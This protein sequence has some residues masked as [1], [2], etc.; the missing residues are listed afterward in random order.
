MAKD[1]LKV[2]TATTTA[3]EQAEAEP[4]ANREKLEKLKQ[5]R[6][7]E[8]NQT[9]AQCDEEEKKI[10]STRKALDAELTALT[11]KSSKR[12]TTGRRG[13]RPKNS[14]PLVDVIV[15][16][17]K[18]KKKGM[19]VKDLCAAVIAAGYNTSSDNFSPMVSQALKK[20]PFK[21]LSRGIYAVEK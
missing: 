2:A 5:A 19:S 14:K 18:G 6:I 21:K 12:R 20:G 7:Q 16:V 4:Q 15:S 1:T 11:G 17:L 10:A 9:L 8:I 3:I 13:P